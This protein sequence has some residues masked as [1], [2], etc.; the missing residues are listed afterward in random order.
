MRH[1]RR[2]GARHHRPVRR[3]ARLPT[4]AIVSSGE[5]TRGDRRGQAGSD[6]VSPWSEAR[7]TGFH[8]ARYRVRHGIESADMWSAPGLFDDATRNAGRL[9]SRCFHSAR[10]FAVHGLRQSR[11]RGRAG[12]TNWCIARARSRTCMPQWVA[13]CCIAASHTPRFTGSAL[14]EAAALPGRRVAGADARAGDRQFG[15][16][17]SHRERRLSVSMAVRDFGPACRTSSAGATRRISRAF[18]AIFDAAGVVPKA[19]VK[20]KLAW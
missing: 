18:Q 11:C 10:P 8:G 4:T 13:T 1:G 12:G 17:R 19:V 14:G 6:R 20:R 16:D 7:S 9:S 5:V 2:F 15:A 3:A